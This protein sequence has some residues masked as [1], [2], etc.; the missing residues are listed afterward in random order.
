MEE[1]SQNDVGRGDGDRG[2]TE[3]GKFFC[4]DFNGEEL[5]GI[6]S[7]GKVGNFPSDTSASSSF[8]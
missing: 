1:W 7:A 3:V 8:A 2:G 4:G 6:T 5:G